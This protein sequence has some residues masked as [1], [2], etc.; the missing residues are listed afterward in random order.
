MEWLVTNAIVALLLPPGCL[1]LMA[2]LGGVLAPRRPSLGRGLVAL[3]LIA[4]W[5][6]ATPY[7]A[8]ALIRSLEPAPADPAA[9]PTGQAIV[10]LG[11]GT[12]F[13][14]PE[15]GGD[16]ISAYTLERVRYA[17]H[18]H[19]KTGKPV[20]VSGGAPLGEPAPEAE[21]MRRALLSDYGI[22]ARWT[23]TGSNNSMENARRSRLV[24]SEAGIQ[25]IYLVTHAW[26]QPRA[27][28]AFEQAGFTVIPAPTAFRTQY[29]VTV[30]DFLPSAM[31][32]DNSRR[33]FHELLGLGWYHFRIAAGF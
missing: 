6:L 28:L 3:S 13:Q 10:V 25:R 1:L 29:K 30:L 20:L 31:A 18:L 14:A 27:R 2:A 24:L 22:A 19:R 8:N 16:T 12:Y 33:Y 23:E 26:H 7:I 21:L 4:L 11:G 9:D 17:A 15:Y 32:L 5:A